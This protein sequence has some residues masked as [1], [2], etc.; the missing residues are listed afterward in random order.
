MSINKENLTQEHDKIGLKDQDFDSK[1]VKPNLE[2]GEERKKEKKKKK[3]FKKKEEED[4]GAGG[5]GEEY[6]SEQSQ[7]KDDATSFY[8]LKLGQSNVNY[9][10]FKTDN[11]L[12]ESLAEHIKLKY[13]MADIATAPNL[14]DKDDYISFTQ[15]LSQY[16]KRVAIKA[17]NLPTDTRI[18]TESDFVNDLRN[19]Y[20][21]LN[22]NYKYEPDIVHLGFTLNVS[23]ENNN[24]VVTKKPVLDSANQ[25]WKADETGYPAKNMSY[26][27]V[28]NT[29]SGDRPRQDQT[30]TLSEANVPFVTAS[31]IDKT[32]LSDIGSFNKKTSYS[33]VLDNINKHYI[34]HPEKRY[35]ELAS[36]VELIRALTDSA[37]QASTFLYLA[38]DSLKE[39]LENRGIITVAHGIV[40][41]VQRILRGKSRSNQRYLSGFTN[42]VNK[43]FSFIPVNKDVI[44]V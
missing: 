31:D 25:I 3:K 24:S 32:L 41:G 14:G 39:V 43:L 15:V 35:F 5:D 28:T 22:R 40:D 30:L 27:L 10:G 44:D 42:A 13:P 29:N 33:A 37:I 11:P 18:F 8:A 9:Q 4:K 19:N 16:G 38:I 21:E 12:V 20:L 2:I 36:D 6:R 34:D 7:N 17:P 26:L 23:G 1:Q